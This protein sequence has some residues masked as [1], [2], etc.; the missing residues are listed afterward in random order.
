MDFIEMSII[1]DNT[2]KLVHK[3][4]HKIITIVTKKI[5]IMTLNAMLRVITQTEPM[6][7]KDKLDNK[8]Y[9]CNKRALEHS[10]AN[11]LKFTWAPIFYI[12]FSFLFALLFVKW[13]PSLLNAGGDC[14]LSAAA[15]PKSCRWHC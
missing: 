14:G 7:C 5:V 3:K 2:C 10:R 6:Y 1:H 9:P 8:P 12:Y 4:C 13:I 15:G 11:G